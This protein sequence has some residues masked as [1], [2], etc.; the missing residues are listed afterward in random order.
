ML[1]KINSAII[2]TMQKFYITTPIYYVNAAPHIGTLYTTVAADIVARFK[3]LDGYDVKF[4]TGTDEH[5]QK[6][7]KAA[8]ESNLQP[9]EFVDKTS[10]KFISLFKKMNIINDDFIRTTETRHKNTA[11]A[12]WNKL[13]QNGHIYLGKYTGWYSVRDESFYTDKEL[14]NGKAPTGAEVEKI[15]EESYFFD[16]SKWQKKLLELYKKN[17]EFVVPRWRL[18][19]VIKIVEGGLPDLS[20]S[21]INFKWGIPISDNP[22]H[23]M[24]VWLDALA[25]Y[26]TALGY[27]N[28]ETQNF[29][30]FWPADVHMIGKDITKFHAIYWPAIL[31]AADLPLPKQIVSHG[32]WTVKGEKMSKSLKNV[33]DPIV[34]MKDYGV[35]QVRYY[36]MR[37]ISFGEDGGF[38]EDSLICRANTELANKIGNLLQ[39]SLTFAYKNFDRKIPK[40]ETTELKD[41][42]STNTILQEASNLLE[43][44]KKE[45]ESFKFNQMLEILIQ[46]ADTLNAYIDK[47]APWQLK[48]TDKR[49][50]EKVLYISLE[51]I[52]YLAILLLPFIP[53]SAEKMLDQMSVPKN[54]REFKHLNIQFALNDFNINEPTIIFDKICKTL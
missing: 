52:R 29:K 27:P 8:E 44:T 19:E 14:V 51:A 21:R 24:Y 41:I 18:N 28:T 16:L 9:Q 47:Q 7:E 30:D 11:T 23:V 12:L 25:N 3:K 1:Y 15:S 42:Y 46:F 54:Q 49:E 38:S 43:K 31:M 39:R 45:L 36:M 32:W 35:D 13:K 2:L 48:K 53:E 40:F 20:I 37:E 50:A 33:I 17:P 22:D 4:I 6:I 10:A 26:I 5:G 34:L